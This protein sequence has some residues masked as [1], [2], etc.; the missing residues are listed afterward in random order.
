MKLLKLLAKLKPTKTTAET[1]T[2]PDFEHWWYM[3]N[4]DELGYSPINNPK[5]AAWLAWQDCKKEIQGPSIIDGGQNQIEPR[6]ERLTTKE[7][8]FQSV[9]DANP[10]DCF[11]LK[12]TELG[13]VFFKKL[14]QKG[15]E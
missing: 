10:G 3:I 14:I 1:K 4:Q 2:S 7:H 6:F 5:M 11:E 8:F 12:V 9:E 15:G 13:D